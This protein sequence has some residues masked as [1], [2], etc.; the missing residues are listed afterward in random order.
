MIAKRSPELVSAPATKQD[1]WAGN[2]ENL[3]RIIDTPSK[4]A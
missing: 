1:T 4:N 2:I 3:L